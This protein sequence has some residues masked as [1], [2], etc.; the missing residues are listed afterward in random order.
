VCCSDTQGW[1]GFHGLFRGGGLKRALRSPRRYAAGRCS[2][3]SS[4][5]RG[6]AHAEGAGVKAAQRSAARLERRRSGRSL[7]LTQERAKRILRCLQ[8][9]RIAAASHRPGE[10]PP[11]LPAPDASP[12]MGSLPQR[13][14]PAAH[15][16]ASEKPLD[17]PW[18]S[19]DARGAWGA[20][21]H[22]TVH[23]PPPAPRP[24]HAC[25]TCPQA[26]T[27]PTTTIRQHR[28]LEGLTLTQEPDG[29]TVQSLPRREERPQRERGRL[30]PC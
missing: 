8:V 20:R 22:H 17:L 25:A 9:G 26:R 1:L 27:G 5:L 18:E 29:S 2:F 21:C 10:W 15:S 30:T 12:A 23:L 24:A 6:E 11:S 7:A 3:C 16:P 14:D 28:G 13:P 4:C 19:S